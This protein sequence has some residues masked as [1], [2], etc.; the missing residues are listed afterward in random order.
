MAIN[1]PDIKPFDFKQFN[2]GLTISDGQGDTLPVVLDKLNSNINKTAI[3]LKEKLFANRSYY[4]SNTGLNT[5]T[6]LTSLSPLASIN[7]ALEIIYNKLD[8]NGY[9]ITINLADGTYNDFVLIDG[10]PDGSQ[11]T[12]YPITITGNISNPDLVKWTYSNNVNNCCALLKNKAQVLIKDL[13]FNNSSLSATD[14]SG[15][16]AKQST[17]AL[18]NVYFDEYGVNNQHI[19]LSESTLYY[20]TLKIKGT[21][22]YFITADRS[23]VLSDGVNASWIFESAALISLIKLSN[24]SLAMLNNITYSGTVTGTKYEKDFTSNIIATSYPL[25]LSLTTETPAIFDCNLT[26]NNSVNITKFLTVTDN[27]SFNKNLNVSLNTTLGGNLNIVGSTTLGGSLTTNQVNINGSFNTANSV[28]ST[29]NGPLKALNNSEFLTATFNDQVV[30]QDRVTFNQDLIALG[31]VVLPNGVINKSNLSASTG[32]GVAGNNGDVLV[33]DNTASNGL[34]WSPRL[35]TVESNLNLK[36]NLLNPNFTG[37]PTTPTPAR[38]SNTQ[39]IAN[40]AYVNDLVIFSV[41]QV[42]TWVQERVPAEMIVA[43]AG[44]V[45]SIPNNYQLCDGTNGSPDLRNKFIMGAGKQTGTAFC[46]N[47][48]GGSSTATFNTT[49]ITTDTVAVDVN[50]QTSSVALTKDQIPNHSHFNNLTM[51]YYGGNTL[52]INSGAGG[53]KGGSTGSTVGF[54][55]PVNETSVGLSQP[56]NH[57]TFGKAQPHSHVVNLPANVVN[58]LPPYYVLAYIKLKPTTYTFTIT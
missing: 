23:I 16:H 56:H 51:V 53:G 19:K 20:N 55:T 13:A 40:T 48:T 32:T 12:V 27:V 52:P 46:V 10:I 44:S 57:V 54:L 18:E 34:L 21:N 1:L 9:K 26:V 7:N 28:L 4:I 50:I 43:W 11:G 36:A 47:E 31:S 17:L 5:N 58:I 2:N 37:V 30:F 41:N 42:M 14:V 35:S 38:T 3:H 6:G 24:I 45:E 33:S 29:F 25:G 8:L 49:N 39:Q 22:K 15:V